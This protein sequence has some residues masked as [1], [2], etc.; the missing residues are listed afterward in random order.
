[1]ET[2]ILN[3]NTLFDQMIDIYNIGRISRSKVPVSEL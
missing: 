1:M 3:E 2:I